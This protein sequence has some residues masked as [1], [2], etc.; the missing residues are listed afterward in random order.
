[1]S[2]QRPAVRRVDSDDDASYIYEYVEEEVVEA[3]GSSPSAGNR[4]GAGSISSPETKV[5]V[6]YKNRRSSSDVKSDDDNE[7]ITEEFV[8]EE[9]VLEETDESDDDEDDDD[10]DNDDDA[11][12]I[13]EIVEEVE[14]LEDV[15]EE[16]DD[17]DDDDNE[18]G[19]DDNRKTVKL[20]NSKFL[21]PSQTRVLQAVYDAHDSDGDG[22]DE[23]T[24]HD[25]DDEETLA[26][27]DVEAIEEYKI[28]EEE[29][30]DGVS[31]DD[32]A[33]AI[34]YILRQEK[35]V[36]NFILTQDQADVMMNLPTKIMKL[37]VDHLELCDN[38]GAPI[39]WDF[40]LKIVLPFCDKTQTGD[41]DD[42]DKPKQGRQIGIKGLDVC[43]PINDKTEPRRNR[44]R[45]GMGVPDEV[46]EAG[47]GHDASDGSYGS[48]FQLE[49]VRDIEI[50]SSISNTSKHRDDD[51][52]S[53]EEESE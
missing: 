27:D 30:D 45:S 19:D 42:D 35:A 40:L 25:E 3:E 32:L 9:E 8:E 10:D 20:S 11:E 28:A 6:H 16:D 5:R 38:T 31:R 51:E 12:V 4:R 39:D 24:I 7:Y 53:D 13:E 23:E 50:D 49:E 47:T 34:E 15:A 18:E 1:M 26:E 52:D 44:S 21:S 37:I 33:E 22:H 43:I 36:A 14:V 29:E 17:D 46:L 2:R 41:D 48:E